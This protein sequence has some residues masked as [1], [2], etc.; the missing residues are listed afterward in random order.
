MWRSHGHRERIESSR[1]GPP[2]RSWMSA[3]WTMT[4]TGRPVVSVRRWRLD[5]L[6]G[7]VAS[8]TAGCLDRLAVDYPSC[9]AGFPARRLARLHQQMMIDRLPCP[10]VAPPVEIALHGRERRK[11]L[12]QQTPLA[13]ALGQVEDRIDHLAQIRRPRSATGAGRRKVS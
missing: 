2:S 8:G 12:G 4:A 13:T 10:I 9:R 11:I 7:I 6:A 1:A 3:S 5:L